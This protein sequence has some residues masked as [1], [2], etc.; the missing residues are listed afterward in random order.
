MVLIS[1][2][3]LLAESA[4]TSFPSFLETQMTRR[5][6]PAAL[7]PS[8]TFQARS[9]SSLT[10]EPF[11][12]TASTTFESVKWLR[13]RWRKREGGLSKK[14]AK[15]SSSRKLEDL[16]ASDDEKERLKM[17]LAR[18]S[19]RPGTGSTTAKP[20]EEASLASQQEE[21]ERDWL[22]E[23]MLN[24]CQRGIKWMIFLIS[25]KIEEILVWWL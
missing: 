18:R 5:A 12:I 8:R 4:A 14:S 6:M 1:G 11:A 10:G 17:G 3:C 21:E 22:G 9:C 7:A 20:T 15:A 24:P 19:G 25:S 23:E 2:N 16:S 13:G